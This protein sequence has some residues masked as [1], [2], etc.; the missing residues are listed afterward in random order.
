[1]M[2]T[3]FYKSP[4]GLIT[5]ASDGKNLIG[6]WIEGQT[7]Y[8][9]TISSDIKVDDGLPVFKETKL[10]LDKYFMGE[11]MEIGDLPLLMHGSI[12]REKVW[13]L[14]SKIPYGKLVTYGDI[15]KKMASLSGVNK[16]SAQAVGGAV[17]HNPISIIV[18]CHRVVGADG[19]L[20][21]YAGG[22]DLKI[23][24][25]ELEGFTIDKEKMKVLL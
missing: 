22:L 8:Q 13:Q 18:P 4:L 21:G 17:G 1:M 15:A 24:L 2:Y 10:W 11:P 14:L 20:T 7:N 16:M 19:K 25:L 5:L 6:L 12:F 9:S 23:K 3:C